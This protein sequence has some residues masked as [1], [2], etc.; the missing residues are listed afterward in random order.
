MENRNTEDLILSLSDDLDSGPRPSVPRRTAFGLLAGLAVT[1]ALFWI[2]WPLRPG[3]SAALSDPVTLAKTLLPLALAALALPLALVRARPAGQA[4]WAHVMWIVPGVVLA[5]I[6]LAYTTTAPVERMPDFLG[7]SIN[8]CL[9]SIPALS[10]PLLAGLLVALRRGAPEHPARLG[11]IA[12]LAAAGMGTAIYSLFCTE[13]SPLFYGT[14][15]SLA[16]LITAGAGALA[17]H[18]WLRW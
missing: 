7:H 14:W 12:G 13:D 9:P 16:I 2:G 6:V 4:P 3:L 10:A 15:Y 18:R 5:L 17:A 8:V 11:A 1:L